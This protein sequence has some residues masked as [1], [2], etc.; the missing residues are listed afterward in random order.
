MPFQEIQSSPMNYRHG[1]GQRIIE[2]ILKGLV[3][4]DGKAQI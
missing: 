1:T 2:D 3:R 4:D